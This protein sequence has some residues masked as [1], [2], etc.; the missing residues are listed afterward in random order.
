MKITRKKAIELYNTLSSFKGVY[1][2][3]FSMYIILNVKKMRSTMEEI[4][5]MRKS[6]APSPEYV[7]LQQKEIDM[8][9]KYCDRDENRNP[10]QL[11]PN[12]YK[13]NPELLEEYKIEKEKLMKDNEEILRE[14]DSIQENINTLLEE[15][16][17]IDF[18]KIP[19]DCVPE[20]ISVNDMEILS[21]I[22]KDFEI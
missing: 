1:N 2:K 9:N 7:E 5:E 10:I 19:F 22:V 6:S 17:E 15:E 18:I 8:L 11:S 12:R 4:E 14:Y 16:V 20:D 13:I 3:S 21:E